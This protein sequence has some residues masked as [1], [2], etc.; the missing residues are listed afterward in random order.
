MNDLFLTTV[1]TLD[2]SVRVCMPL[3]FASMAGLFAER[4]GVVDIGLE[5]KLLM[6]AFIAASAASVFWLTLARIIICR[7][8]CIF[9][10]SNDSWTLHR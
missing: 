2:A 1:L 5:G 9:C 10:P 7:N 4:S 8:I 6:S 3:I